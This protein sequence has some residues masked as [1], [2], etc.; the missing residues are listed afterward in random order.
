MVRRT[1]IGAYRLAALIARSTSS[2]AGFVA[3]AIIAEMGCARLA[4]LSK[5]GDRLVKATAK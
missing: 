1:G 3:I 5:K 2:S 4:G